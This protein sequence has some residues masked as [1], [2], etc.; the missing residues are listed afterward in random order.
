MTEFYLVVEMSEGK[1]IWSDTRISTSKES[2][3][4]KLN[5]FNKF[6]R[7]RSFEVMKVKQFAKVAC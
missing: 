2:A 4:T 7:G 1:V 6:G 5:F 3:K